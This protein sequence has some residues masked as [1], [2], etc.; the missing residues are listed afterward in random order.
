MKYYM[1]MKLMRF[2]DVDGES[3]ELKDGQFYIPVFESPADAE[4][5]SGGKYEIRE[6]ETIDVGDAEVLQE[7][8]L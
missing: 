1:V 5:V 4:K 8:E 2:I 6:I 3:I 7:G